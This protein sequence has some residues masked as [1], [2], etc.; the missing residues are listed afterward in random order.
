M[1][2]WS[3]LDSDEERL[4]SGMQR[5][6]YDAD[7]ETYSYRDSDG[8]IWEGPPGSQYGRLTRVSGPPPPSYDEDDDDLEGGGLASERQPLSYDDDNN[9]TGAK[10]SWRHE[11][12]PLLNFLVLIGLFLIGVFWF[13]SGASDHKAEKI[14]ACSDQATPHEIVAGD[15]C[16]SIADAGGVSLDQLQQ[17]NEGVNCDALSVG[18]TIC[19]PKA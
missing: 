19:V 4:P 2:R 15:T 13:L 11:M 8:S 16:W 10:P 6:G 14:V 12:M 9:Y 3:H 7:T 1:G 5:I 18:G 17:E